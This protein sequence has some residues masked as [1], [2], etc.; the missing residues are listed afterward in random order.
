MKTAFSTGPSDLLPWRRHFRGG[1]QSDFRSG[2]LRDTIRRLQGCGTQPGSG[3]IKK[4]LQEYRFAL[5]LTANPATTRLLAAFLHNS[6]RSAHAT[7]PRRYRISGF[8]PRF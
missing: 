4:Y 7:L 8:I 5:V 1:R 3:W 6:D 2:R